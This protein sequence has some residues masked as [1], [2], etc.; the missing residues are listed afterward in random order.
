MKEAA[1]EM[2]DRV[3]TALCHYMTGPSDTNSCCPAKMGRKRCQLQARDAIKAMREP[4]EAMAY[5]GCAYMPEEN[6]RDTYQ[7]MVDA[8]L[9]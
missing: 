9:K 3:A 6:I 2:V 1:N 8:A 5:A 4:T 7:A